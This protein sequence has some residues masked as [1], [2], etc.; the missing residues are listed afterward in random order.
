MI[1]GELIDL[2]AGDYE[3]RVATSGA[4]LVH[5][6][7]AGSDLV[8]PFDA[9]TQLAGA[10]QGKSL[11]PWPNRIAGS[12]YT[13]R[14]VEYLL[15]CNEP[16]TGSALHGLVGWSD[17]QVVVQ[18]CDGEDVP[19]SA[20]LGLTLPGSYGYPWSLDIRVRFDLDAD[21]GLTV[22]ITGTN[23]GA[24]AP[25]PE[26]DGAPQEDGV[27]APAPY[28][29]A[30]HPYLTRSVPLDECVLEAPGTR[31]LDVDER[32]A[33]VGEHDV[34]GTDQ[35]WRTAR[36]VG[37]TVID[38]AFTGLPDGTW[39][40]RLRGGEGGRAVVLSSD[41]PWFQIYSAENLGRRGAAVEAMS[42]PPDAFNSGRDL[43]E[44]EV[45][46]SHSFSLRLHEED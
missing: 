22:T 31:V 40:V 32:M 7:A 23:L 10:W 25:G 19:S 28:G 9:E 20:T 43:I 1:N 13:Y 39:S 42:C 2:R 36:T 30:F 21:A 45:G 11:A 3:A 16:Q 37:A 15:A 44:L 5:L 41:A 46:R 35:D 17:F 34:T 14:G 27:L 33:P 18:E 12:R 29:V 24:A 6:R 26:V 4:A 38:N 8:I